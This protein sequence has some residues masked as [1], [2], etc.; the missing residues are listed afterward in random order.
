M[1]EGN[2]AVASFPW[3]CDV[4]FPWSC[5]KI[6]LRYCRLPRQSP[7]RNDILSWSLSTF[8]KWRKS[9]YPSNGIGSSPFQ[10]VVVSPLE[11]T[12][13]RNLG[14]DLLWRGAALSLAPCGYTRPLD[15]EGFIKH[16]KD[17]NYV[18]GCLAPKSYLN[19]KILLCPPMEVLSE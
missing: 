9:S 15:L 5:D 16:P 12:Y 7:I 13:T 14:F 17:N 2:L 18:F 11:R 10:Q 19:Y 4:C 6:C 1:L 8:V 3:S